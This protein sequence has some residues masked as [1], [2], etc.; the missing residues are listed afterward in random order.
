MR[1]IVKTD[2]SSA[3]TV[4]GLDFMIG[5][6]DTCGVRKTCP[7]WVFGDVAEAFFSVTAGD[8]YG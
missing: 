6:K 7:F 1:G 8:H 4:P 2:L 5:G 3:Q